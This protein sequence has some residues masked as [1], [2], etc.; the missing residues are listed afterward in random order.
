[1]TARVQGDTRRQ[2]KRVTVAALVLSLSILTTQIS[3]AWASKT[4]PHFSIR[5]TPIFVPS[6]NEPRAGQRFT[7]IVLVLEHG[8]KVASDLF[9]AECA[10]RIGSR[11]LSAETKFVP[12][13]VRTPMAVVCSSEIP[14]GTRGRAFVASLTT[15][16]GTPGYV[17]SPSDGQPFRWTIR[18][19]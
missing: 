4:G 16:A 9:D 8:E 11:R 13:G 1:M 3:G 19:G 18:R 5:L 15:H 2:V 10:A 6:K 7:A 17:R 14:R 12:P